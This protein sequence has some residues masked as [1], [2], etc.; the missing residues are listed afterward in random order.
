M[1][2]QWLYVFSIFNFPQLHQYSF[3][4][5]GVILKALSTSR[6]VFFVYITHNVENVEY[7][8]IFSHLDVK[9]GLTTYFKKMSYIP[10]LYFIILLLFN[11]HSN[12]GIVR[13]MS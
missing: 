11:I 6:F 4:N 5:E 7:H 9:K 12:I 3:Q 10:F 8:I 1:C 13:G 2:L